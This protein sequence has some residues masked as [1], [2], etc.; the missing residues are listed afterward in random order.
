MTASRHCLSTCI[1]DTNRPNGPQQTSRHCQ[2]SRVILRI[3]LYNGSANAEK[4]R[5]QRYR[6]K[7]HGMFVQGHSRSEDQNHSLTGP[8]DRRQIVAPLQTS[9]HWP[10]P[11]QHLQRARH[12][13]PAGGSRFVGDDLE[14]VS[15]LV[16]Y[17]ARELSTRRSAS[18]AGT[19]PCRP[20]CK[21][22][23]LESSA[24]HQ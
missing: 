16:C 2:R 15:M 9:F 10:C 7:Y 23:I 20:E 11:K 3:T 14:D 21:P 6:P 19:D 8:F 1:T 13:S 22:T 18:R 12:R 5:V 4:Q 17:Q 24:Q